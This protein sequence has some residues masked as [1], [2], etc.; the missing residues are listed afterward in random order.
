[1]AQI[2][3][4]E[5]A[6]QRKTAKS[7]LINS[8]NMYEKSIADA[9]KRRKEAKDKDGNPIYSE[10]D[11]EKA[12]Q[13]MKTMQKDVV[14]RFVA[15]GGTEE[16]LKSSVKG[17]K[18]TIDRSA[19]E[20][21]VKKSE[22]KEEMAKYLEQMKNLNFPG[23]QETSELK[24]QAPSI[25]NEP[26]IKLDERSQVVP[27]FNHQVVE[28]L[29]VEENTQRVE[30]TPKFEIQKS[31]QSQEDKPFEMNGR[32]MFGMVKLPS[33]GECYKNKLKEL[34]VS[35][36]TAY[37]ENMIFSP[38]LY[39]EGEFL[40]HIAKRKVMD[41][42]DVDSL[43]QGDIEAI[44]IWLRGTGYGNEYPIIVTDPDT[45]KEFETN[46]DLTT[47]KYKDFNLKGDENGFF[48]FETPNTHDKIKFRFLTN[49][50]EKFLKKLKIK[51][52]NKVKVMMLRKYSDELLDAISGNDLID[53]DLQE[54]IRKEVEDVHNEIVSKYDEMADYTFT[55]ELT[56]RLILQTVSVNGI[57][58]RD[59]INNYIL[60]MN[61]KDASEYRKFIIQ[62]TPGIDYNVKVE[63]PKSLGG[64]SVS[65]FL[66]FDQF[67]FVNI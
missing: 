8:Y 48:D 38:N 39:K 62:N 35:Y 61:I 30:N 13:L 49:R 44:I 55:H 56:D 20:S 17:K 14:D 41:K 15:L 27:E 64:G 10:K 63:R 45:G 19:L 7:V 16:E 3:K 66:R 6:E 47:L 37:D 2:S 60:N 23:R 34:R 22:E 54:K 26:I 36:L 40:E 25:D 33:K 57:E 67:I 51:E 28:K 59:Y 21:I 31:E 46:I 24:I 53:N 5:L 50:D 29:Q 65:T 42:I 4:E 9:L 18:K 1:M 43:L 32:E 12:L 11:T 58:N 52:S